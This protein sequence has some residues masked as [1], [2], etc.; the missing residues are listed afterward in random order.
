MDITYKILIDTGYYRTVIN[1]YYRQRPFIFWPPVQFGLVS[2]VSASWLLWA[3]Q[4]PWINK[5]AAALIIAAVLFV[6]G[7]FLTKWGILQR[8][9]H[10]AEFGS[11]A[12]VALSAAGIVANGPHIQGKWEWAAYPHSVR[13]LDGILLLR[14]GAIRW[15]PDAAIQ[16]GTVDES[17]ALIASKTDL[18]RI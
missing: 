3:L 8:Y 6:G 2:L 1:R 18:R 12:T 17:I 9:M 5:I 11:E 14:P 13:F 4:A 15:L 16:G 7:V 10:R